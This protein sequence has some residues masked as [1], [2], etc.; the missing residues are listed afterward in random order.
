MLR[1][2]F[3]RPEFLKRMV[4][5]NPE[6]MTGKANSVILIPN[7]ER[8]DDDIPNTIEFAET[9]PHQ[10][11][12]DVKIAEELTEE[13]RQAV[14]HLLQIYKDVFSDIPGRTSVIQHKF[15]SN[16]Y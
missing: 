11:V 10:T 8:Q 6:E 14:I 5:N 3:D 2:F 1:N 12:N 4:D 7:A 16:R 15:C 9:K 13:Q